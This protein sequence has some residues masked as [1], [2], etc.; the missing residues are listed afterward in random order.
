MSIPARPRSALHQGPGSVCRI[1]GVSLGWANCTPTSV[2]MG[3]SRSTL[4][5]KNPSGCDIRRGTGDVSGGTTLRQCCDVARASYGV[6]FEVRTGS[7]VC[8]PNYAG[9]KLHQGRGIV[10]QGS[11]SA[12]L[13]TRFQSTN[14]PVNH[15]VWVNE[16]RG[17]DDDIPEEALVYDPAADGRRHGIADS[18]DWWPWSLLLHFA[19]SLEPNG[20][21]TGKLGSGRWYCAIAPDTEP[22][23]HAKFGGVRTSPFPDR[24][25]ANSP[26]GR[27]INVHSAPRTG[28]DTVIDHLS[29]GDLFTAYQR[30]LGES[31]G[32]SKVWLGNHD[33]TRW[34]HSSRLSHV[35]GST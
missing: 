1:D 17:W 2:A 6:S 20:E 4:N 16:G 24:T 28:S 15:A 19:A 25:R 18:P 35:G 23:V 13:G 14:G 21:G 26:K 9:G 33:G 7:N 29:D 10:V 5:A 27:R 22:H 32:G 34:V 30:T 8:T 3:V 31:F 12:L 11:T